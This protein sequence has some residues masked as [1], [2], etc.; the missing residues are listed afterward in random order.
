MLQF[1]AGGC[2]RDRQAE[3]GA[4]LL[5]LR[6]D[7]DASR[8]VGHV[9]GDQVISG[10][11][12]SMQRSLDRQLAVRAVGNRMSLVVHC[13]PFTVRAS[14][15]KVSGPNW[16]VSSVRSR[17]TAVNMRD[18]TVPSGTPVNFEISLWVCP[19]K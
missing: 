13:S 18:F 10:G 9:C 6:G 12:Q 4:D 7:A 11:L 3:R 5:G 15:I 1:G 17:C 2:L 8:A 19:P 14:A 16:L